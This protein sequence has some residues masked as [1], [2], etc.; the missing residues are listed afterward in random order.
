MEKLQPQ[1]KGSYLIQ[2]K[3]NISL[4]KH[5]KYIIRSTFQTRSHKFETHALPNKIL[6]IFL[7][8][9]SKLLIIFSVGGVLTISPKQHTTEIPHV[10]TNDYHFT[11]STG[12]MLFPEP[13]KNIIKNE[14]HPYQLRVNIRVSSRLHMRS[15]TT[16]SFPF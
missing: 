14:N 3:S 11:E 1:P 15:G 12:T 8:Y 13:P 6:E 16:K 7:F 9:Q 4:L 2:S 10:I 5:T